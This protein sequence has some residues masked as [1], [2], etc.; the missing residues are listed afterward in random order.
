LNSYS[1]S[2]NKV[3]ERHGGLFQRKF[4]R[5]EIKLDSYL[6]EVITYIH[7]N[8]QKHGLIQDFKNWNYSSYRT[9]FFKIEN[10]IEI[11]WVIDWFGGI[12]EFE[13]N[14]L[15]EEDNQLEFLEFED[16]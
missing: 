7:R 13:K 8:P 14:H 16:L 5:K 2:Y 9:F 1:K 11:E 4:K 15:R 10:L 6:T 3:F 12:N